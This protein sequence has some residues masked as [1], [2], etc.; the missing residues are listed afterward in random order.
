MPARCRWNGPGAISQSEAS[1]PAAMATMLAA[2]CDEAGGGHDLAWSQPNRLEGGQVAAAVP[3]AR[4]DGGRQFRETDQRQHEDQSDD[5]AP[6]RRGRPQDCRSGGWRVGRPRSRPDGPV[7]RRD[8]SPS[9][10]PD[11][12]SRAAAS[13]CARAACRG[14]WDVGC[15]DYPPAVLR[16]DAAPDD[17]QDLRASLGRHPHQSPMRTSSGSSRHPA[18]RGRSP[19]GRHGRHAPGPVVAG[20]S[21]SAPAEIAAGTPCAFGERRPQL[22]RLAVPAS[23]QLVGKAPRRRCRP[24]RGRGARPGTSGPVVR[25]KQIGFRTEMP[26]CG[27]QRP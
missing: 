13:R 6:H 1:T 25:G 2:E 14:M 21:S 18:G 8:G 4:G 17:V 11:G 15:G 10:A 12:R 24:A 3:Y 26:G 5:H 16:L 19:G 22:H 7:P 23:Q 20:M 9:R 27:C